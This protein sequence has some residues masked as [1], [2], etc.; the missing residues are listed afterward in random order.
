MM[1]MGVVMMMNTPYY[2]PL[3]KFG[4]MVYISGLFLL[5]VNEFRR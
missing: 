5:V 2:E 3:G 1:V 4:L